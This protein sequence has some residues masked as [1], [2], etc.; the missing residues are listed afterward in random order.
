[1]LCRFTAFVAADVRVV[2]EGGVV[3]RVLQPVEAPAGWTMFERVG[4]AAAAMPMAS[5]SAGGLKAAGPFA[6]RV[7][8]PAAARGKLDARLGSLPGRVGPGRLAAPG[9]A[10]PAGSPP[11]PSAAPTS[12]PTAAA[13]PSSPP[14]SRAIALSQG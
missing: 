12:P 14:C 11:S 3:H 9:A 6:G 1:M 7:A 5:M 13:P 8:G 4:L 2:N 10:G